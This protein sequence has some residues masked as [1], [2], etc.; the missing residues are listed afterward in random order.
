MYNT[1]LSYDNRYTINTATHLT[2]FCLYNSK[3]KTFRQA[4][5]IEYKRGLADV[6][7]FSK[8]TLTA[9]ANFVC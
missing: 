9:K 3:L 2:T 7:R 8:F 1:N 5:I 6:I 4:D